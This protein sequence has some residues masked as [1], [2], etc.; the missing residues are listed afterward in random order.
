M[1]M[2]PK[3]I[4]L[5]FALIAA[6]AILG[7]ILMVRSQPSPAQK[8]QNADAPQQQN[9]AA[10]PDADKSQQQ[11]AQDRAKEKEQ[12]QSYVARFFKLVHTYDK[13]IVALGTVAIAA[14]TVV[15][16]FATGFLYVATRNL[17]HETEGH[18]QRSL[19]AYIAVVAGHIQIVNLNDGEGKQTGQGI[20]R[21]PISPISLRA[22]KKCSFGAGRIIAIFSTFA[23]ISF[24]EI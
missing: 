13:E 3:M 6:L 4:A 18:G 14:F 1:P 10:K 17:V 2:T 5:L 22:G 19:R 16:A 11:S 7:A 24:S 15:L 9:S 12:Q 8:V 23:D 20:R 21:R